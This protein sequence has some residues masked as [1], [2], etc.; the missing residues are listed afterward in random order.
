[1][2]KTK[3]RFI[4]FLFV[5]GNLIAIIQTRCLA[6]QFPPNLFPPESIQSESLVLQSRGD[7]ADV[8]FPAVSAEDDAFQI[9]AVLQGALVDKSF[10]S[11]FASQLARFGF[12]VVVPNHLQILGPPGSPPALFTDQ[13]VVND[14]LAQMILED[15][16]PNSSVFGIVDTSRLGLAGHSFGGSAGLFAIEGNCKLPF[17][18]GF[19]QRPKALR[20]GAFYGTNTFDETKGTFID[21]NTGAIPVALVQ[22]SRDGISTSEEVQ[23]TFELLDGLRKF[24]PIEGANHYGITN[25]DNPQAIPPSFIPPI[26]DEIV[27]T[28]SQTES[29]AQ[30]ALA[31]GKFL[32]THLKGELIPGN[33]PVFSATKLK[34]GGGVFVN[35][36][37]VEKG[38]IGNNSIIDIHGNRDIFSQFLPDLVPSS[39]PQ[40][41]SNL[42]VNVS[43]HD[44][45]FDYDSAVFF[46]K[47]KIKQNESARFTGGGPFHISKLNIKKM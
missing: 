4:M 34:V 32:S 28:V 37:Q 30:I 5:F 20:A 26:M 21:V 18:E 29:I 38:K 23:D 13:I 41:G 24:K 15:T 25:E 16:N 3:F 17:C 14:V 10:Y 33:F 44:P 2:K 7:Q 19:F 8:Y 22:G 27:P 31:T 40:N 45:P 43:A 35:S 42:I 36:E 6:A 12:V 9:V 1:M 11:D 47:I 46:K 39:F